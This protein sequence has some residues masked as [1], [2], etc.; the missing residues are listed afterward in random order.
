M[1]SVSYSIEDFEVLQIALQDSLGVVVMDTQRS[2]LVAR[3]EPLLASHRLSSL[4]SLAASIQAEQSGGVK[5][6]ILNLVSLKQSNWALDADIKDV[7]QSYIFSQLPDN[8]RIWLV[9]CEQGQMAYSVAMEIKRFEQINN[10]TKNFR[11][12]ATDVSQRNINHA[13]VASYSKQQ[14]NSLSEDQFE[15]FFTPHIKAGSGKIKKSLRDLVSFSQCDLKDDFQYLGLLDLIICPSAMVYFSNDKK[16]D[17][18]RR[19]TELLKCGGILL[20]GS[21]GILLQSDSKLERVEHPA[22]VFYRKII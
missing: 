19:L 21:N 14:L 22:G 10:V 9:G 12:V 16:A 8:A 6:E 7:L 11:L 20:T 17:I 5:A 15:L 3:I 4:A 13:E 18:Q 1:S 2:D